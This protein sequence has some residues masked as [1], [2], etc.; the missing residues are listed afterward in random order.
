QAHELEVVARQ[1]KEKNLNQVYKALDEI[2]WKRF[3]DKVTRARVL[4]PMERQRLKRFLEMY[5]EFADENRDDRRARK[6]RAGAYGRVGTFCLVLGGAHRADRQGKEA[7]RKALALYE[8]LAAEFPD[9]AEYRERQ[10][11]VLNNLSLL[12]MKTGQGEE[13]E[14]TYQTAI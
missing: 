9:E 4:D 5:E 12:L 8:E 6:E 11:W 10:G 1:R 2:E 7:F 3:E 13:A 14:R